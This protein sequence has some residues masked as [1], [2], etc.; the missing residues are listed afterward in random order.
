MTLSP[1]L[2]QTVL[3]LGVLGGSFDPP[4][5][6]HRAL[7]EAALAQFQL[8]R[9]H[10]LPTGV[11]WH[12]SRQL[13]EAHHRLAMC[14]LA[15]SDLPAIQ[16]DDREIRRGTA[17]YTV[18]TLEELLSEHPGAEIHLFIGQ[19]QLR[20][21]KTWRRWQDILAMARLVVAARDTL[22]LQQGESDATVPFERLQMSLLPIS[23]T[24]IRALAR[25][26]AENLQA[27][28]ALVPNHVAS[29][30]SQHSLYQ[31]PS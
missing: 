17:S 13:T 1:A 30:I 10:I 19:D 21:F 29:Y 27:L 20:A 14:A 24:A 15:F 26:E 7:A 23:S 22:P 3:R 4:H 8:D 16:V 6:G 25:S 28:S 11:A 9:L 12:K 31:Q 2:G 18:D 5:R